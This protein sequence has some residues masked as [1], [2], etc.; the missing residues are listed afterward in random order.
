M[1]I[2]GHKMKWYI[3]GESLDAKFDESSS[4]VLDFIIRCFFVCFA[5]INW[6]A[7]IDLCAYDKPNEPKIKDKTIP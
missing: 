3:Y 5:E 4:I 6:S 1:N 7:L 2:D